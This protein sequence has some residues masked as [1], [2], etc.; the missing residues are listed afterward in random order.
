MFIHFLSFALPTLLLA[1]LNFIL[2]K[3]TVGLC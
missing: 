3:A 1:K 2:S